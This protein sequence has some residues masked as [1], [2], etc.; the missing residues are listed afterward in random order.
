M[1][2]I[3]FLLIFIILFFNTF[4]KYSY[5]EPNEVLYK[6]IK[7][8]SY[9]DMNRLFINTD[10][11]VKFDNYIIKDFYGDW[12]FKEARTPTFI[13]IGKICDWSKPKN[14]F[15]TIY[16]NEFSYSNEEVF[17]NYYHKIEVDKSYIDSHVLTDKD[18]NEV[19]D[20]NGNFVFVPETNVNFQNILIS[21]RKDDLFPIVRFAIISK[22][23]LHE[24]NDGCIFVYKRRIKK[25]RRKSI[26]K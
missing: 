23:E 13:L 24:F 22:D 9:H 5:A 4:V 25:N 19:K 7:D 12:I 2:K 14:S 16:S 10:N 15:I 20:K 17:N 6:D 26:L 1:K 3:N 8:L 18:G 21:E 11:V